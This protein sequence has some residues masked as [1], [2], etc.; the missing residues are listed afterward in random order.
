MGILISGFS[1]CEAFGFEGFRMHG[2]W[3]LRALSVRM[4][5]D[6]GQLALAQNVY[7]ELGEFLGF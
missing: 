4:G 7:A 5:T 1:F 3:V 2:F 6:E